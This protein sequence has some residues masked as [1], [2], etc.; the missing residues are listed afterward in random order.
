MIFGE[1]VFRALGE[2]RAA[3][4]D[5]DT[6]ISH[7]G[8]KGMHWGVRRYQNPDGSLTKEG[9]RRYATKN[10]KKGNAHNLDSWGKDAN[11]NVL[12]IVGA[13][14][15]GK[16]TTA[17]GLVDDHDSVIHL[18][19]LLENEEHGQMY[20]NNDFEKFCIS[21][22]IDVDRARDTSISRKE[23]WKVIDAISDQIEPYGQQ[24][25]NRGRRVVVEGVQ[26]ADDTMF[27]DKVYFKD[28]P[29]VTLHTNKTRSAWR[30]ATRD[31]SN[32]IDI[33]KDLT[34]KERSEWYDYVEEGLNKID[35]ANSV[36]HSLF[37]ELVTSN[38]IRYVEIRENLD[39]GVRITRY[40]SS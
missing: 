14:G 10:L 13:S 32:P 39:P 31:K 15:S 17:L 12:Y 36:K 29:V 40:Y 20:R 9:L 7:H 18:D 37:G 16:S 38:D 28:R 34:D 5:D 19:T 27:P 21:K 3:E 24:C 35:K 6:D 23:R 22:G 26:M 33:V 8:I 25:Y 4:V 2:L 11:H 1:K 30:A